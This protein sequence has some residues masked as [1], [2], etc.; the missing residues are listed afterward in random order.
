VRRFT[1]RGPVFAIA[2]VACGRIDFAH[3]APDALTGHDEDGDGIPDIIDPCPHIPGDRADADGDGVGDACDPN[4]TVPTEHWL[5]FATL[6]PGDVPF[7]DASSF[8]QEAD[9]LHLVGTAN[10]TITR[11]VGTVRVDIGY[12]I[13]AL[14]GAGQHQVGCGIHNT[15]ASEYY[16]GELNDNGATKDVSIVQYDGVNG[17][18]TIDPVALPGIHPG[19]GS[20]RLDA[21]AV[22]PAEHHLVAGWVGETYA[23]DGSTPAYS[24]GTAV[25]CSINGLDIDLRY[26]VLIATE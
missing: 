9:S 8:T 11:A 6:Q 20:L 26:V 15:S 18:V 5:L 24:G 4:P 16:F 1:V 2:L 14:D 3:I 25:F 19:V 22:A 12:T 7:D 10:T 21:V 17:Y 23:S 13:N